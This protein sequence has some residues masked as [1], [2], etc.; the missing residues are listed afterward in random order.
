MKEHPDHPVPVEIKEAFDRRHQH[1]LQAADAR[2]K[3][4]ELVRPDDNARKEKAALVEAVGRTLGVDT[5]KYRTPVKD[6]FD[7]LTASNLFSGEQYAN[8]FDLDALDFNPPM[9]ERADHHFWWADSNW[10]AQGPYSVTDRPDGLW[11]FGRMNYDGASTT[12][13]QFGVKARFEIQANRIPPSVSGR[14]R[15]QPYVELWGGML[16]FTLD[17]G[18]TSGDFWSTCA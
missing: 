4:A 8:I 6:R 12:Y 13:R 14:Y 3:F 18:W 1:Q 16:G 15:S 7:R 17:G 9:P 11:F 2:F 5:G 10:W